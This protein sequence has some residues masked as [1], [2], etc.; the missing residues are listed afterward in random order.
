MRH[1]MG[2]L[3]AG[4]AGWQRGLV[5]LG[6][7][8]FI[9]AAWH[10]LI[11][12][13]FRLLAGLRLREIFTAFALFIVFGIAALLSFTVQ[14]AVLP[15]VFA[16]KPLLVVALSMLLTP[17]LFI[18]FDRL[19]LPR[20][21]DVS[22]RRTDDTIEQVSEDGNHYCRNGAFRADG[23]PTAGELWLQADGD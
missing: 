16:D 11:C 19:V 5:T 3:L 20:M 10:Y 23:Q 17:L 8:G 1:T 22:K 14:S 6:A 2:Q 12:P 18:L 21:C 15:Q 9:V 13:V 4:M 7:I